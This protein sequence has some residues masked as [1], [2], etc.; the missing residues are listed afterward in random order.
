MPGNHLEAGSGVIRLREE[1]RGCKRGE[2]GEGVGSG[3]EA[4]PASEG[5]GLGT[6]RDTPEMAR[7]E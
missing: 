4:G 7:S 6:R 3:E 5:R 1:L 2:S